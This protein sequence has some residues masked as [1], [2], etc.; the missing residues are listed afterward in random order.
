MEKL[1]RYLD[2]TDNAAADLDCEGRGREAQDQDITVGEN[3]AEGAG[4]HGMYKAEGAGSEGAGRQGR[5]EA[6]GGV[7]RQNMTEPMDGILNIAN[8]EK[9][10]QGSICRNIAARPYNKEAKQT[11]YQ[12]DNG[13]DD[14]DRQ[15]PGA[16]RTRPR[17]HQGC[18]SG[19]GHR[20]SGYER[21]RWRGASRQERG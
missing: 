1:S 11:S 7:E 15:G 13:A 17:Q 20:V 12:T 18:A 8:S 4:R 3:E 2:E 6:E 16:G 5:C 9:K 19:W 21:G 10:T 14:M